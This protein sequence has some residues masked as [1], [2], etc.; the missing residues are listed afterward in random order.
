MYEKPKCYCGG[1]F[2]Y[3]ELEYTEVQYKITKNG[4]KYK[5]A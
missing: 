3:V 5:K 1:E 2:L 4:K